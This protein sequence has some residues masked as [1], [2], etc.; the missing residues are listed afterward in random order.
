MLGVLHASTGPLPVSDKSR[1]RTIG[2]SPSRYRRRSNP[3]RIS[4]AHSTRA[5]TPNRAEVVKCPRD[6]KN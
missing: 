5:P 3:G 4:V 2:T 6:V 1:V